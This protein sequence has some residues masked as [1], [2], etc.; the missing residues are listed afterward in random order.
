MHAA[1]RHIVR[2]WIGYLARIAAGLAVFASIA[3]IGQY[4]DRHDITVSEAICGFDASDPCNYSSYRVR[5]DIGAPVVLN[6]DEGYPIRL[7]PGATTDEP[8]AVVRERETWEVRTPSGS[9]L[10]CLVLSGHR[11]KRDGDRLSVSGAGSCRN[12]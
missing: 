11:H 1:E 9:L 3:A 2:D 8:S 6:V 10:G 7:D 12:D 5:N 4:M